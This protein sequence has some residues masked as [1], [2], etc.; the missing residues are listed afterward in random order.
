MIS[1]FKR[2][3][4]ASTGTPPTAWGYLADHRMRLTAIASLAALG[5]AL[6]LV[7]PLLVNRLLSLASAGDGPSWRVIGLLGV[8]VVLET[9]VAIWT[10]RSIGSVSEDVVARARRDLSQA[11]VSLDYLS[12]PDFSPGDFVSRATSDAAQLRSLVTGGVVEAVG[13]VLVL[14]GAFIG[15]FAV[16]PA[17]AAIGVSAAALA[18]VFSASSRPR[19]RIAFAAVQLATGR[20][21]SA[22][23]H[24]ARSIVLLRSL[25]AEEVAARS[26]A[27][28]IEDSFRASIASNRIVASILPTSNSL[29]RLAYILV[30]AAGGYR[31]AQGAI[32]MPEFV[33]FLMYYSL[34]VAPMSS[35]SAMIV[36]VQSAMSAHGRLLEVSGVRGSTH[37]RG[38][39]VP[40]SYVH[41]DGDV[42]SVEFND[43][44]FAYGNGQ[45]VVDHLSFIADA[46][47]ITAIVGPS[48]CGKS[49]IFNLAQGF[50]APT[51][52]SIRIGGLDAYRLDST[53]L[54]DAIG[55]VDQDAML[56][57]GTLRENLCLGSATP[58]DSEIYKVLD[59]VLLG[60]F[61]CRL[62]GGLDAVLG[63][64]RAIVSGGERQRIAFA[65]ALLR[66][67]RL[68]LLDEPTSAIDS[69]AEAH[70]V[71]ILEM[72][73]GSW[74]T[75][76]S[77]HRETTYAIADRVVLL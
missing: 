44:S 70:I 68:L 5:S 37:N 52:G 48:G 9:V 43:V 10:Q 27:T 25:G 71:E 60:D 46:G 21:G 26:I 50:F 57:P 75:L 61:V 12:L 53:G 22:F 40:A 29:L 18:I 1:A 55:F 4:E 69:T 74:T 31:T 39:A 13:G 17:A 16:D 36:G 76:I 11:L 2:K 6:A 42:P 73:R 63:D 56:I 30:I 23:E 7:Q 41:S 32:S 62:S 45:R 3:M 64:S 14:V 65:R 24:A 19:V 77:S 66:K 51:S 67:P 15:L 34:T 59:Q 35:I 38:P 33:A 54:R 20:L 58:D 49:T 72:G 8:V 47:D 28:R